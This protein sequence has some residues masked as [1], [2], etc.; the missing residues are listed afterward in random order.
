V[1]AVII[2]HLYQD[3]GNRGK[4]RAIAGQDCSLVAAVPAGV[5]ETVAGVRIVPI[6]AT[7]GPEPG[8]FRWDAR[9]LRRLFT[10]IRP[11]IVQIEEEPVTQSSAA[12]AAEAGRLQIPVVLF[13]WESLP[14]RKSFLEKRRATASFKAARACI[15]GNTL[16]ADL[17]RAELPDTPI[18]VMP[19]LGV[20]ARPPRERAP[21]D[22]LSIGF[23]GRLLPERG[24]DGLLRAC[25]SIM[26]PWTLTVAGTGPEQEP[27]EALAQRLGLAS[28]I[29]WLGGISRADIEALL[30]N[31]DC[32]VLP[33]RSTGDWV[34]RWSPVLL[35]A[36]A[37]G[38]VPVVNEGGALAS[39]VEDVGKVVG[40][41]ESLGL[42]LQTLLAY[43]DERLRL[44]AAARQRVLERY[45]DSA[46]AE[47]T[48][49]LWRQVL[50][51]VPRPAA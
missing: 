51:S 32:L 42:A 27:L 7:G 16:A 12:A 43:P 2:S 20:T 5:A 37:C 21:G 9:A 19:Q 4:L 17:L 35:D 48:V 47:Q 18:A 46:L 8:A 13:S 44:G 10:D 15:A 3:P 39:V 34:E 36:M 28:R 41:D 24:V 31:L 11:D 49:A 50:A 45:V 30:P 25:A 22:V 6:P 14:R 1:R 40:D 26:G 23:V 29:R 38:V 33:S